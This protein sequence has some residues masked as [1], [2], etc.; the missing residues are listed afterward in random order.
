MCAKRFPFYA[1]DIIEPLEYFQLSVNIPVLSACTELKG[2]KKEKFCI[3]K[4]TYLL[5]EKNKSALK[6][7]K[8]IS[9]SKI[10]AK[11]FLSTLDFKMDQ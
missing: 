7:V 6:T 3:S 5:D 11:Y 10:L 9:A 4:A 8:N 1:E 2:K